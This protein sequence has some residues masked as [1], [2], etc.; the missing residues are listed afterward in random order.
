M[1]VSRVVP[2]GVNAGRLDNYGRLHL[3][4]VNSAGTAGTTN[5][6]APTGALPTRRFNEYADSSVTSGPDVFDPAIRDAGWHHVR[7]AWNPRREV[8]NPGSPLPPVDSS[9]TTIL[10]TWIAGHDET[11]APFSTFMDPTPP[12]P[13]EGTVDFPHGKTDASGDTAPVII[14]LTAG[15]AIAQSSFEVDNLSLICG[16][17]NRHQGWTHNTHLPDDVF[18]DGEPPPWAKPPPWGE[19][20]G[21]E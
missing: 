8:K 13:P 19:D 15:K 11:G 18:Y 17:C 3:D 9:Q 14:G 5:L 10:S 20:E 16:P 12:V 7:V 4:T 6:D 2:S 1:A 21:S